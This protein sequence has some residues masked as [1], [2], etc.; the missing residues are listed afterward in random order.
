MVKTTTWGRGSDLKRF[1]EQRLQ[2]SQQA[3]ANRV[4]VSL[5]AYGAWERGASE[6]TTE[7]LANLVASLRI[8]PDVVGY[9]A[10]VGWELVPAEWVRQAIDEIEARAS[11]RHAETL[12]AIDAL[13]IAIRA[14]RGR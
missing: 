11:R 2:I 6:P 13:G 14:R 12:Q 7:N 4:G 9:E 1:R 5:G 3:A 8:P 10:P